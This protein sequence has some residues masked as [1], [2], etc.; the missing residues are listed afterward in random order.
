MRNLDFEVENYLFNNLVVFDFE[1]ITVHDQSLNHTDSTT[2]IGKHVTISVS[3]HCNLVSELFF[4]CDINPRC[5]V[6]KLL[7][8]LLALSKRSSMELR[9]LFHPY[10]QLIQ[11]KINEVNGNLPQNV[12]DETGDEASNL[13][14]LRNLKK[15]LCWSQDWTGEVL[16]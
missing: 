12:D 13:K 8:E 11:Q 16:R 1:S 15:T 5:L 2:F 14:L 3:I 10:F 9:Q 6:T 4:I 7:L